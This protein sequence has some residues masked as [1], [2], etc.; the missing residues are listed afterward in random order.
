MTSAA[1]DPL[2]ASVAT[3]LARHR[4]A[5]DALEQQLA[6]A[7]AQAAQELLS[8]LHRGGKVLLLGNGGSAADAQ[9]FAAEL[10]GRSQRDR[11]PLPAI[12]L[13]ADSSVLTAIGNDF[14][15][16]EVF[17]RQVEALAD[18]RDLV[19]A[20]ST[21]GDSRN[22]IRAM[23][24]AR[25][26]GCRTLALLGR[27]GGKVRDL[28]DLPLV[29]ATQ[30]TPHIQEAHSLIIHLLCALID[31]GLDQSRPPKGSK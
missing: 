17:A 8:C 24:R 21:S 3:L 14:G 13:T 20:L 25:D 16:D 19:V 26:K 10:I 31:S 27:D 22:V 12:A 9:H 2:T 23:Q 11:R 15:F 30:Q 4:Q 5:I 18:A 29:V 28:V 6:P 1:S 7:I